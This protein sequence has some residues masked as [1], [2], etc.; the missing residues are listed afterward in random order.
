MSEDQPPETPR[1]AARV[2]KLLFRSSTVGSVR[3]RLTGSK[4]SEDPKKQLSHSNSTSALVPNKLASSDAPPSDV[5]GEI[6]PRTHEKGTL[7]QEQ[8]LLLQR[9]IRMWLIRKKVYR[10]RIIQKNKSQLTALEALYKLE[11]AYT[12]NLGRIHQFYYTPLSQNANR[13]GF[14]NDEQLN[15]LLKYLETLYPIHERHLDNFAKRIQQWPL[16]EDNWVEFLIAHYTQISNVLEQFPGQLIEADMLC[17][18]LLEEK[19]KFKNFINSTQTKLQK[20]LPITFKRALT[21]PSSYIIQSTEYCKHLLY[22]TREN[23][24]YYTNLVELAA[25][26]QTCKLFIQ[27]AVELHEAQII[28]SQISSKYP[29]VTGPVS[30]SGKSTFIRDRI[31][32]VNSKKSHVYLFYH[33]LV[34][35]PVS[36]DKNSEESFIQIP[37]RGLKCSQVNSSLQTIKTR[38][39]TYSLSFPVNPGLIFNSGTN[40]NS[41]SVSEG[42]EENSG[43]ESESSITKLKCREVVAVGAYNN[44]L[45]QVLTEVVRNRNHPIFGAKIEETLPQDQAVPNILLKLVYYLERTTNKKPIFRVQPSDSIVQGLR[46]EEGKLHPNT[47][48]HFT[49]RD[50]LVGLLMN[51]L[52]S[53]PEPLVSYEKLFSKVVSEE[54]M[55]KHLRKQ[56]KILPIPQRDLLE[57]LVYFLARLLL[58]PILSETLTLYELSFHFSGV[59]IRS[60]L[61]HMPF[62]YCKNSSQIVK[63]MQLLITERDSIFRYRV[64]SPDLPGS[65]EEFLCSPSFGDW[66]KMFR[67]QNKTF[68]RYLAEK[69]SVQQLLGFLLRPTPIRDETLDSEALLALDQQREYDL[70]QKTLIFQIL[71]YPQVAMRILEEFS[72]VD[73]FHSV[74]EDQLSNG[75]NEF[76][77]KWLCE[78]LLSFIRVDTSKW[79]QYAVSLNPEFSR[80][81]IQLLGSG[82]VYLLINRIIG[83]FSIGN[84][85]S[86]ALSVLLAFWA[87]LLFDRILILEYN[88]E[89]EELPNSCEVLSYILSI[90]GIGSQ[91]NFLKELA[92]V[93]TTENLSKLIDIALE[94]SKQTRAVLVQPVL[95]ALLNFSYSVRPSSEYLEEFDLAPN[96]QKQ[97]LSQI[98]FMGSVLCVPL[99]TFGLFRLGIVKIIHTM[100]IGLNDQTRDEFLRSGILDVII[101]A[102]FTYARNSVL[103]TVTLQVLQLCIAQSETLNFVL[104]SS[105]LIS[106]ILA[107]PIPTKKSK[108]VKGEYYGHIS[109]LVKDLQ[110]QPAFNAWIKTSPHFTAWKKMFG[111]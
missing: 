80:S 99:P 70:Q 37:L 65:I 43:S 97:I 46:E 61:G 2:G 109:L 27:D 21:L 53:I 29:H 66:W 22:Q 18:K 14:P 76:S 16:G 5:P 31:I 19:S 92:S 17:S 73:Q 79:T 72:V 78:I 64:K 11:Y 59:I 44:T 104:Q 1:S 36:K 82:N 49:F 8:I 88:Y 90:S 52:N 3:A 98:G 68:I 63:Y 87:H 101:K 42:G 62:S 100:T 105:C 24:R 106:N 23:Q 13:K 91:L 28:L 38:A 41:N 57:Y 51:Y 83:M 35:V 12:T 103:H 108:S 95:V 6:T 20:I 56:I 50:D 10:N 40:P 7:Y 9:T 4:K 69:H 107:N 60:E 33:T 30:I 55:V 74:L 25:L 110:A 47:R 34:I 86:E 67:S 48:Y 89:S 54:N 84:S 94:E 93:L 45:V 85:N 71:S 102:F 77:L 96:I 32:E 26:V 81:L 111:V 39:Y 58:S 75:I 15:I